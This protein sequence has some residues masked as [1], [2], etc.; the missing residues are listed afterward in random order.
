MVYFNRTVS[1]LCHDVIV[2]CM[3]HI[4]D[5]IDFLKVGFILYILWLQN[6]CSILQP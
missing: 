1:F 3:L 4:H 6:G 2:L 5:T